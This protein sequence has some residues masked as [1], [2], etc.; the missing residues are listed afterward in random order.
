MII[1]TYNQSD[2]NSGC[3]I[4]LKMNS[5]LGEVIHPQKLSGDIISVKNGKTKKITWN[6]LN[7]DVELKGNYKAVVELN[8]THKIGENYLGGIVF[9]VNGTGNHAL[10]ADKNDLGELIWHDAIKA[11]EQKGDGWYL[12]SKDDLMKLY[13][14]KYIIGGFQNHSYW[15]NSEIYSDA[16]RNVHFLN[17]IDGVNNKR[18]TYFVRAVRTFYNVA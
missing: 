3:D 13:R 16:G 17:C 4:A 14:V 5:E 6:P 7:E 9:W 1:V 2:C 12:P 8:D 10:I 18:I 15:S 11:C